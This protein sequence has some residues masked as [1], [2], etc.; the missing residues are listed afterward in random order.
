MCPALRVDWRL[1]IVQIQQRSGSSSIDGFIKKTGA[2][3]GDKNFDRYFRNEG[4]AK[5]PLMDQGSVDAREER[6]LDH[7]LSTMESFQTTQ[8]Q[9]FVPTFETDCKPLFVFNETGSGKSL[10]MSLGSADSLAT[11]IAGFAMTR[12]QRHNTHMQKNVVLIKNVVKQ[13]LRR[14]PR[15]RGHGNGTTSMMIDCSA[16]CSLALSLSLYLTL[17]LCQQIS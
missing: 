12:Y 5:K 6:I 1:V 16:S 4:K 15:N 13:Q 14:R 17:F 8:K 9:T 10:L 2:E 3:W 11:S 7:A